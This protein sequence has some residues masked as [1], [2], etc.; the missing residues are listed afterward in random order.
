MTDDRHIVPVGDLR[1]HDSLPSCW[2]KPTE[3]DECP[4][5]WLHHSMDQR[6]HTIEQGM[7]Q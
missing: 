3:D 5:V 1:E 2:C 6:E 4:G 7:V